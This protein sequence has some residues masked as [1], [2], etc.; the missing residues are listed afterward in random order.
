M[1]WVETKS[2]DKKKPDKKKSFYS[3]DESSS[4]GKITCIMFPSRWG[5]FVQT[6]TP[7]DAAPISSFR[8]I[9]NKHWRLHA[10]YL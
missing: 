1:P 6:P 4:E 9:P 10:S 3:E 7:G 5:P 2:R 8:E